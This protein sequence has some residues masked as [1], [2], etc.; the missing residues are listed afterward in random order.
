[1][2]QVQVN[3]KNRPGDPVPGRPHVAFQFFQIEFSVCLHMVVL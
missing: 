3:I 1:M 2:H